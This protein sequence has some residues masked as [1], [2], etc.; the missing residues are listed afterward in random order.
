MLGLFT[1]FAAGQCADKT[2]LG[3]L[4]WYHYLDL[5]SRCDFD[6]SH[7]FTLLGRNSDLLFI[8][9]AIVDDLLRIA[10]LVAVIFIIYASIKYVISQ[11][12]PDETSQAKSTLINALVGL[13][14]ALVA[15]GLISFLGSQLVNGG[16]PSSSAGSVDASSLPHLA[17]D[18]SSVITKGLSI[19]LG[20]VG[21]L[22]FLFVVIGGF[23]YVLSQGDPQA[24]TKAK[25]TILYAL[26]GLVIAIV[27]QTIVTFVIGRV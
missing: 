10:G 9:L 11:G 2:F 15:V 8:A 25:N 23:R 21:A 13:A 26:I 22:S 3:L 5:N 7:P 17:D 27:A 6:A 16:S 18:G 20:V 1:T 24:A 19:T 14:V 4:P 12:S